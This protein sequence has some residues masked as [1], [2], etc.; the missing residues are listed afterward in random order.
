LR[1][2]R[3]SLTRRTGTDV[4][5]FSEHDVLLLVGLFWLIPIPITDMLI[6]PERI[7]KVSPLE[8]AGQ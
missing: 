5:V 2:D 1:Y 4:I 8:V 7:K 3:L 6:T